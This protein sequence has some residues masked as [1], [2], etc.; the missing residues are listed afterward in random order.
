[1]A[2]LPPGPPHSLEVTKVTW[3]AAAAL[4]GALALTHLT[5]TPLVQ[6][7]L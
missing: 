2:S 4:G 6:G 1:M 3:V 5:V 7:N